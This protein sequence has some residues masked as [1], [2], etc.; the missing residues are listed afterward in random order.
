MRETGITSRQRKCHKY[1]SSGVE[2]LV[3]PHVLKR[4][5]DVKAVN[6]VWCGT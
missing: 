3:S 4:K 2:A 1:K 6:Q 5:F